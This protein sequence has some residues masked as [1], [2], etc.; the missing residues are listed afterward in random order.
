MAAVLWFFWF[1]ANDYV[2]KLPPCCKAPYICC[3]QSCLCISLQHS[4]CQ[5]ALLTERD[6]K[7][8]VSQPDSIREAK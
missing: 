1:Y 2:Y 5:T 3:Q 8:G 4:I 7:E 6:K